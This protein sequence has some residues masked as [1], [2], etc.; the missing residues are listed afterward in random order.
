MTSASGENVSLKYRVVLIANLGF[1]GHWALNHGE[2]GLLVIENGQVV[3]FQDKE[4]DRF[5]SFTCDS[6]NGNPWSAARVCRISRS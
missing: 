2:S 1:D 4:H 6:N 3:I 5:G